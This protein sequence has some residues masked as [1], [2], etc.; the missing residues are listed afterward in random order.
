MARAQSD[1]SGLDELFENHDN[2]SILEAPTPNDQYDQKNR[3]GRIRQPRRTRNFITSEVSGL[4]TPNAEV[5]GP[6]PVARS[7]VQLTFS[8]PTFAGWVLIDHR[9]T[10]PDCE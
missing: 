9:I 1:N 7:K 2:K 10:Q 5:E 4:R 3:T 8:T 6:L